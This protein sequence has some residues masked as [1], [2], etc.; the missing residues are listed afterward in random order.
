MPRLDARDAVAVIV[1]VICRLDRLVA[2]EYH[3]RGQDATHRH[4]ETQRDVLDRQFQGESHFFTQ[5]LAHNYFRRAFEGLLSCS[6]S[7]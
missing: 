2:G 6:R 4:Q 7:I 1:G 3:Q 5:L